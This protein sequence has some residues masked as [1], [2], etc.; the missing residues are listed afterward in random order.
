MSSFNSSWLKLLIICW[1]SQRMIN[2]FMRSNRID[3]KNHLHQITFLTAQVRARSLT[4]ILDVMTV[5]CLIALQSIRLSYSWKRYSSELF[6]VLSSSTN[7]ASLATRNMFEDLSP[8]YS[9]V[10][11]LIS[12][13]YEITRSTAMRWLELKSWRNCDSFITEWATSDLIMTAAKLNDSTH[14]WNAYTRCWSFSIFW[15]LL[16]DRDVLIRSV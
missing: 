12:Y 11:F 16:Y 2:F 9:I 14:C 3:L 5:T 13:K 8:K 15:C 4:S 1:F 6:R 10:R 7:A